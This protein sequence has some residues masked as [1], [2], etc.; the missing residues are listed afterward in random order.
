MRKPI[1]IP[2][3]ISKELKPR[4]FLQDFSTPHELYFYYIVELIVFRNSNCFFP[5]FSDNPSTENLKLSADFGVHG[6]ILECMKP[7]LDNIQSGKDT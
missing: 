5:A 4:A 6:I 2:S 1:K 3:K 7:V